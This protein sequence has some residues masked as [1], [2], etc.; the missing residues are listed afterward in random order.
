MT[1]TSGFRRFAS[2]AAAAAV[3]LSATALSA[4]EISDTHLKAAR[5]AIDAIN[6]TDDFDN[7][8]PAIART[9]KGDL[10][11]AHPNYDALIQ[12]AVDE[13]TFAMVSRRVDLEREVA[14]VYAKAFSEADLT[15]IANF[16]QSDAGKKL[17]SDGPV[18]TRE[19]TNAVQIWE[20]GIARDLT[21]AVAEQL[22]KTVGAM[23]PSSET[24]LPGSTLGG[25]QPAGG[26]SSDQPG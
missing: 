8:L 26:G 7:I 4:Q 10:L 6:A 12:Q 13:Q 9:I 14:L 17:L 2:A 19:M 15:A 11:Q 24:P 20:R 21:I 3:L 16:Y 23:A 5:A 22:E 18:V 25:E 1:F